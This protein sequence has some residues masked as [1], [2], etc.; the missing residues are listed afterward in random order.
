M[1]TCAQH[2]THTLA[3][4][5]LLNMGTTKAGKSEVIMDDVEAVSAGGGV[6]QADAQLADVG[7]GGMELAPL[8]DNLWEQV[9]GFMCD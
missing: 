8:A 6:A 7:F 9:C 3:E 4:T 2:V 1:C 5:C